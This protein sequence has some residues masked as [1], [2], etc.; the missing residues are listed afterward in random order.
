MTLRRIIASTLAASVLTVFSGASLAAWPEKPITLIVPYKAGG[1][2][3]SM[4][5]VMNKA[6]GKE[7]GAKIIIRNMPGG[8]SAVGITRMV[9]H[10]A[11]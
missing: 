8:G 10:S 1:T 6:L 2:T 3:H 5:Q 7:L 4:S 11:R 9:S